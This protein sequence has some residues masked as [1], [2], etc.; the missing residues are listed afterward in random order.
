MKI[1]AKPGI[2]AEE[3]DGWGAVA[4]RDPRPSARRRSTHEWDEVVVTT[5]YGHQQRVIRLGP[6]KGDDWIGIA[7]CA[8]LDRLPFEEQLRINDA[9]AATRGGRPFRCEAERACPAQRRQDDAP[10]QPPSPPTR[11]GRIKGAAK[12]ALWRLLCRAGSCC[13]ILVQGLV[14]RAGKLIGQE[15]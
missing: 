10:A 3:G 14:A 2:L 11:A 4:R 13:R 15:P 5:A 8:P 9:V 7:R 1:Q 12:T 6:N